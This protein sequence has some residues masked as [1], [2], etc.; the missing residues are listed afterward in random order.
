MSGYHARG[1]LGLAVLGVVAVLIIRDDGVGHLAWMI[2]LAC[3]AWLG[4]KSGSA[5]GDLLNRTRRREQLQ[6][7]AD[8]IGREHELAVAVIEHGPRYVVTAQ[9]WRFN[10]GVPEDAF[11]AGCGPLTFEHA[12]AYL[13]GLDD[14]QSL[15]AWRANHPH[16]RG[17]NRE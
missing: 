3:L 8:V 7:R 12:R 17:G 11:A 5:A 2:W 4:A 16:N 10:A 14:G 13:E 6:A 9:H 15:A 1:L